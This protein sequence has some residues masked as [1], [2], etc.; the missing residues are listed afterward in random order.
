[1]D[2]FFASF[3]QAGTHPREGDQFAP[4]VFR[5]TSQAMSAAVSFVNKTGGAW[6]SPLRASGMRL[7]NCM[8]RCTA[9]SP[10]IGEHAIGSLVT[11][12]PPVRRDEQCHCKIA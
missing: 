8:P 11:L 6:L 1:M 3:A 5:V 2:P 4:N 12:K 10:E 7:E 9:G